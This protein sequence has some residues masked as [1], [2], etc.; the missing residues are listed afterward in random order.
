MRA[1][2][3]R[4][5]WNQNWSTL[6]FRLRDR[7][8]RGR[9]ERANLKLIAASGLF[10]L[11]W[12][13]ERNADVRAAG[14]DALVHYLRHGASEGRDPNRLFDGAWYLARNPQVH[15]AGMNPL[16]H[17]LRHGAAEGLDPSESFSSQGYLAYNPDVAAAYM[18][19]L[20]HYLRYGAME[21]R[22]PF[23]ADRQPHDRHSHTHDAQRTIPHQDPS[24]ARQ[25]DPYFAE[26]QH[27]FAVCRGKR[28]VA[29]ASIAAE[30][31]RLRPQSF[32]PIA[33]YLPQMHPIPENDRAWGK[34]FTEWTNVCKATPQF[35]EHY[36]P[37]LPGELGFYDLRQPEVMHRQIE[38]AKLYGLYAFCFHYYWFNGRRLL[39]RPLDM[40][41]ANPSMN[42]R[43]CLCWANENWTR[44][45]DGHDTDVIIA[46]N[47]SEDDHRRIFADLL[48]YVR[49]PRYVR[50]HG[51]PLIILY[52]P[53]I[54]AGLRTLVRIWRQMA[55]EAGLPG[56]FLVATNSFGFRLARDDGFDAFCEF[57][58]H[59]LDTG[60][61]DG[62]LSKLN[63]DYSGFAY[64]Y[65]DVVTRELAKL[66][67]P[68]SGDALRFPGVM[69]GWD[70]EARRPGRGNVFHGSTPALFHAWLKGAAAHVIEH[71]VPEHRLVFI[72]AWNEWAEG[73]YLE[74]DQ[75]FGYAY[76][77]ALRNVVSKYSVNGESLRWLVDDYNR[78]SNGRTCDTA[79][80]LHIFYPSLIAEFGYVL[81]Q[82]RSG[83][84]LD[85]IVSIPET[86]SDSDFIAMVDAIAPVHVL[87]TANVGRDIW[88]FIQ[89]L[90]VGEE[91]GYKFGCKVHSKL[92]THLS[93]GATWRRRLVNSLLG[94]RAIDKLGP[95]FF[96]DPCVGFAAAL[97]SVQTLQDASTLLHNLRNMK[98]L[99]SRLGIS[100]PEFQEFVAGSMFWFRFEAL[101]CFTDHDIDASWFG[102]ELGQI[103]GTIA[104]A[105]ERIFVTYV[106]AEG[107]DVLKYS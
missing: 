92:S 1:V 45:W 47:H 42:I 76:L 24:Q 99:M 70:N 105:F 52:R 83:H 97:E 104:H 98:N 34:G 5:F 11:A 14:V 101:R 75:R 62:S 17:Y 6:P 53:G 46:Q 89:V 27:R 50:I 43:F 15:V 106:Q 3:R 20:A 25:P 60:R 7:I 29:Y 39:E 61:I 9:L 73:A 88:P 51:R 32:R 49:D 66:R 91:L 4:L 65:E 8:R 21:G 40:F 57:P 64:S 54:I 44:Q 55:I 79:I 35:L 18:N 81:A 26:Y 72:N 90:R 67:S 74:P 95:Q 82:A 68:P 69:P 80:C 87:V 56:V 31:P 16:V 30:A 71:H 13:L 38:F 22:S 58:P 12:Y 63:R 85:I 41:L 28:D 84:K 107:W 86:W 33:F 94:P 78:R 103:D 2:A 59:G 19:P 100:H 102:E 77:A 10:D 93:D 96:Q 23:G 37:R 36:Q 48:R